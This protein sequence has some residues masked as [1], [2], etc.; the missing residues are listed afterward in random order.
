MSTEHPRGEDADIGR[1]I[2]RDREA[3]GMDRATFAE[4]VGISPSHLRNVENG[5]R[6][7]TQHLAEQ[8][9]AVLDTAPDRY[10]PPREPRPETR[11]DIQHRGGDDA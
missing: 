4:L 2:R 5:H 9:A 8:I 10:Q 11:H 7:V 6:A 1:L 3:A